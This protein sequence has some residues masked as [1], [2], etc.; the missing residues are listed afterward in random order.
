MSL[1]NAEKTNSQ[2]RRNGLPPALLPE[3]DPEREPLMCRR[4]KPHSQI[5]WEVVQSGN[6]RRAR[7]WHSPNGQ[8]AKLLLETVQCGGNCG[9]RHS[10]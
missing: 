6:A 4:V 7:V 1:S 2:E 8:H 9:G 3:A 10:L 5:L